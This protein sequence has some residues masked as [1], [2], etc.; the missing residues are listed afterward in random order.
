MLFAR[1]LLLAAAL[2]ASIAVAKPG[3]GQ[4]RDQ[5]AASEAM[6]RGR[7]MSLKSLESRVVPR[8]PGTN[9][10]GPEFDSDRERYR[11]KFI[12]RD[13]RVIWVDVDA[14]S[15]QIVERSGN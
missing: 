4:K 8:F 2:V 15:G 9:Y 7:I 12:R 10:I 14:R 6:K 13:G 1:T 5:D 3:H 11:M